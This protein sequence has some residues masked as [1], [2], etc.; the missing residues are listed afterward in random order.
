MMKETIVSMNLDAN[1][2]VFFARE[3]EHIK[4]RS[5]DVLYPEYSATRLPPIETDAG[6]GAESITYRQYDHVGV[7]KI[8]S[9]YADDLPRSDVKGKEFTS[10]VR[11]IGGAYGYSVQEI[12]AA[13]MSGK[14]LQQR[15]ANGVRQAYEQTINKLAWFARPGDKKYS[16]LT[17]LIYNPN[18]TVSSATTGAWLT[19]ATPDQIIFDVNEAINDIITLTKGVERPDTVLISQAQFTYIASTPRASVSDTTVLEFLKRVHPGVTFEGIPELASV[20]PKPS[21]PTVSASTNL[22]I[23]FK[24][25]TDKLVQQFVICSKIIL[26][27]NFYFYRILFTPTEKKRHLCKNSMPRRP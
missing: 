25:S 24:R 22:M 11:S 5:Y 7:M 13:Q 27:A 21:A 20:N 26:L 23:A 19:P 12:R 17:G 10:P 6:S 8:L 18:I 15:K 16:G 14:P 9:D 1:E 2:S 3:L 4:A